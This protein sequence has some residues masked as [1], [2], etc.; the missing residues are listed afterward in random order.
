MYQFIHCI[1]LRPKLFQMSFSLVED[2]LCLSRNFICTITLLIT[3]PGIEVT[4]PVS[5]LVSLENDLQLALH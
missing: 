1:S 5:V 3:T 2:D 4:Y